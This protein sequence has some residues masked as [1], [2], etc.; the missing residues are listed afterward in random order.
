MKWKPFQSYY[1]KITLISLLSISVLVFFSAV[2]VLNIMHSMKNESKKK[3]YQDGLQELEKS[4]NDIY[5]NYYKV[6]ISLVANVN[7]ADISAFCQGRAVGYSGYEVQQRFEQILA[8]ACSQDMRIR[9]IYFRNLRDESRYLY[10]KA[11]QG[12]KKVYF[13]FENELTQEKYRRLIVGGRKINMS[14]KEDEKNVFG[15]QSGII[16]SGKKYSYQV[17]VLYDLSCFD[18]ILSSY[19]IDPGVRFLITMADGTIIYDNEQGYLT[20]KASRFEEI[21][22]LTG[23]GDTFID[24][25]CIYIKG[26]RSLRKGNCLAFYLVPQTNITRFRLDK[27]ET[28]VVLVAVIIHLVMITVMV[29]VNRVVSRK[30]QGLERAMLQ[31]GKTNMSYRIPVGRRKDEFF[32]IAVR[33]NQM[34]DE[35]EEMIDKN[36]ISQILQRNAEYKA[37]QTSVNPHFLY[38]SLEAIREKLD[39]SGQND[40]AE[41]VLLL[42]RIFEYQIRGD[43]IVTIYR[44]LNAL[45]NYI[46][47]TSIRYQYSFDYSID[48]E[49]KIMDYIVPKQIFQPI[50]ENYFAHGFRGDEQDHISISGYLDTED[51]MI[52]ICFCD[53]GK[54]LTR[55]QA[56]RLMTAL[57]EREDSFHIGLRNVHNRLKIIF[58]KESRVEI[59]SN[60]PDT[61]IK[62]SL[63]FRPMLNLE[64]DQNQPLGSHLAL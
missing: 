30:F 32:Q 39:V 23:E 2:S 64:E 41:M 28:L 18:T 21:E 24:E 60:A 51:G 62:V 57:D 9:G 40:E 56:E 4:Y 50:M 17:T 33:F 20:N 27:E 48:F 52:H 13:T 3:E 12:M 10:S 34:C 14:L 19:D 26:M 49:D 15:I 25:R 53:N 31:V 5:Q 63:I 7:D 22:K 42:S 43:S 1:A 6:F 37:L 61:G 46:D 36:Y 47:F 54:G 35:L 29:L 44:E 55:E 16:T 8:G 45:Q 38:N 11:D 58:G 59:F